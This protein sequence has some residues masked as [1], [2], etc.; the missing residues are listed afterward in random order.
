MNTLHFA[1]KKQF[2]KKNLLYLLFLPVVFMAGCGYDKGS[3]RQKRNTTG[4]TE[5]KPFFK[6][7]DS[8]EDHVS[9]RE[10]LK[11]LDSER[12]R[13]TRGDNHQNTFGYFRSSAHLLSKLGYTKKA[14]S[15]AM[16]TMN[17]AR[18]LNDTPL[19]F[20]A[21]H[22]ITAVF[23]DVNDAAAKKYLDE[24]TALLQLYPQNSEAQSVLWADWGVYEMMIA[25][26]LDKARQTME[27]QL[28]YGRKT[29]DDYKIASSYSNLTGVYYY[30]N[31]L[32]SAGMYLDSTIALW[33]NLK[34]KYNLY[35]AY[36]NRALLFHDMGN[37]SLAF[38]YADSAITLSREE[39]V[40]R[41]EANLLKYMI[42][43][44]ANKLAMALQAYEN[45][46]AAKDS[47]QENKS[48]Q[49]ND[50]VVSEAKVSSIEKE[51]QNKDIAH[52]SRVQKNKRTAIVFGSALGLLLLLLVYIYK[53]EVGKRKL[54]LNNL[55]QTETLLAERSSLLEQMRQN[56]INRSYDEEMN[57]FRQELSMELH[58]NVAGALAGM[59]FKLSMLPPSH[60]TG[61]VIENIGN[62]YEKVRTISHGLVSYKP[63]ADFPGE[64]RRLVL[65][66][67]KGLPLAVDLSIKNDFELNNLPNRVKE[68]IQLIIQ[69][70]LAN[71]IKHSGATDFSVSISAREEKV[72][73]NFA[74]NGCGYETEKATGGIGLQNINRRLKE[75]NGELIV[76]SLRG[77][78]ATTNIRIP[79]MH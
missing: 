47:L 12:V 7:I 13:L 37:I 24:A 46:V 48:V 32:D 59:K 57:E 62:I 31:K 25:K 50:Y 58:D 63:T 14:L 16:E 28:A 36:H 73:L 4:V 22:S 40:Y 19:L 33:R 41:P 34:N 45:Y 3:S 70:I 56:T 30:K 67:L 6:K 74:D 23:L 77:E 15:A 38:K 8:L 17:I 75:L 2:H 78:G 39:N 53:S 27:K 44:K 26:D 64:I 52:Q 29:G 10:A 35:M 18:H 1:G 9:R 54:A 76:S 20:R 21:Y 61:E 11:V 49:L 66:Y 69:E 5:D 68:Q 79:V 42:Y 51:M 55:R 72:Y 65:G 71:V 60:L 43:K